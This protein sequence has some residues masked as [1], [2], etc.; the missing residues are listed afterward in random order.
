MVRN[1]IV[2]DVA[3]TPPW[4]PLDWCR[5]RCQFIGAWSESRAAYSIGGPGTG[6]GLLL[7]CADLTAPEAA[8]TLAFSCFEKRKT[9]PIVAARW[10]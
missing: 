7:A 10:Q 6:A 5:K 4:I 9:L 8:T 3:W 1:D 2:R